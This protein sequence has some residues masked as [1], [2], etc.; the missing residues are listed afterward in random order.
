MT[1]AGYIGAGFAVTAATLVVYAAS[2][3][4]RLRRARIALL[5]ET[6]E[7]VVRPS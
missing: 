2:I 4:R 3:R 1:D 7:K 5:D 6:H